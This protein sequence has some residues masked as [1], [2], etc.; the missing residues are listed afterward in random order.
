MRFRYIPIICIILLF[1]SS[2]T[3]T[4]TNQQLSMKDFRVGTKGI[5]MQFVPDNSPLRFMQN[6]RLVSNIIVKNEGAGT[7][8]DVYLMFATEK[9]YVSV[10]STTFDGKPAASASLT[11]TWS[12]GKFKG[13]SPENPAGDFGMFE[14]ELITKKIILSKLQETLTTATICYD[15]YTAAEASVCVQPLKS[16][17]LPQSCVPK[18]VVLSSQGAPVAVTKIE[19]KNTA[20]PNN[21]VKSVF[22]IYVENKGSG[23]VLY[24][25]SSRVICSSNPL[26]MNSNKI[27][28]YFLYQAYL[29]SNPIP[30]KCRGDINN[31]AGRDFNLGLFK[32]KKAEIVCETTT[33]AASSYQ[34][35]LKINLYYDYTETI[36][37]Q[38]I[39]EKI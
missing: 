2:C 9:D 39:I 17:A 31:L 37:R 7:S 6:D 27:W 10:A 38:L 28:N 22:R 18:D 19:V 5:T 15:Y 14:V 13:K 26:G 4:L 1:L 32:N 36:S 25:G 16:V 33:P 34:T 24:S 29:G 23:D 21:I 35:P 12:G 11:D 3:S 20:L 30:L 8:S